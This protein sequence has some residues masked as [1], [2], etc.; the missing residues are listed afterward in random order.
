MKSRPRDEL[1]VFFARLL[2]LSVLFSADVRDV[3]TSL[4][5]KCKGCGNAK[6]ALDV[7]NPLYVLH[8]LG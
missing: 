8:R 3:V 4:K 5:L 6:S 7:V 2:L 1:G